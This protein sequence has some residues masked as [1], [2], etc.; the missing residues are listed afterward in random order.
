M[1]KLIMV[2]DDEMGILT[3]LE[4]IF[5]RH[6]MIVS[7]ARDAHEALELL[8]SQT[9]DLFVLDLMMPDIDGIEL[10]RQIRARPETMQTPVIILSARHDAQSIER[11]LE[12]GAN[13]YIPK[14]MLHGELMR[15]VYALLDTTSAG[16]V[17]I[18]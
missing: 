15:Q 18:A 2:V 3:L 7:K 4:I 17:G 16:A 6:G 14:T 10:C 11:G 9:P 1:G 13:V 5:R 12:A 8:K